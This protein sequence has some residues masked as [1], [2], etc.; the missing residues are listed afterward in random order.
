[1]SSL[2]PQKVRVSIPALWHTL[3]VIEARG[4]SFEVVH[5][6]VDAG[7]SLHAQRLGNPMCGQISL[8]I[9]RTVAGA[10]LTLRLGEVVIAARSPQWRRNSRELLA[11]LATFSTEAVQSSHPTSAIC[12]GSASPRLDAES[13]KAL[14]W[15]TRGL[16]CMV[17]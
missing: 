7:N 2:A 16:H 14:C 1:M 13:G 10:L 3:E 5:L 15:P 17:V 4:T 9:A 6:P 12:V 8:C 11:S